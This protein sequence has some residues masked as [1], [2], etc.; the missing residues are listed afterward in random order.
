MKKMQ[1]AMKPP[2]AFFKNNRVTCIC[3]LTFGQHADPCPFF[4]SLT[5]TLSLAFSTLANRSRIDLLGWS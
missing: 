5:L 4:I 1:K 2:S 3:W